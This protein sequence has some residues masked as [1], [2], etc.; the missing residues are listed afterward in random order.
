MH[1]ILMNIHGKHLTIEKIAIPIKFSMQAFIYRSIVNSVKCVSG[2]KFL[3]TNLFAI[4]SC[5]MKNDIE[6]LLLTNV[7]SGLNV[8]AVNSYTL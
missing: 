4:F 2:P 1:Q 8:Y 5:T 3:K 6:V 7:C